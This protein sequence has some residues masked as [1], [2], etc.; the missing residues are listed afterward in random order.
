MPLSN[1][2]EKIGDLQQDGRLKSGIRSLCT[3]GVVPPLCIVACTCK[4]ESLET[5]IAKIH[6]FGMRS[7]FS[8]SFMDVHIVQKIPLFFRFC[9]FFFHKI[10][11]VAEGDEL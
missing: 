3:K 9:V 4:D 2:W 8:L 7:V 1:Q 11:G 5:R 10:I 6:G